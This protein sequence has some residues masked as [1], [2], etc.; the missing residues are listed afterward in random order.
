MRAHIPELLDSILCCQLFA[1]ASVTRN[2]CRPSVRPS[3]SVVVDSKTIGHHRVHCWAV[4]RSSAIVVVAPKKFAHPL[5]ALRLL[6]LKQSE[7]DEGT[8]K[9]QKENKKYCGNKED[10][11]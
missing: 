9:N 2:D 4:D 8:K 1:Y 6:D 5:C 7:A 10:K 11:Y 3:A